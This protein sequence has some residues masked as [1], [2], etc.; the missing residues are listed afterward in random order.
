MP[1]SNALSELGEIDMVEDATTLAR[2]LEKNLRE[3][4]D[5]LAVIDSNRRLTYRELNDEVEKTA[6]TLIN[7]GVKKGDKLGIWMPNNVEWTV[8]WFS[9]TAIGGVV[10]PMD[11]WYKP[12][13][14][15][16]ILGHSDSVGVFIN[17]RSGRADYIAM[18]NEIW[19]KLPALKS[20]IVNG[21]PAEGMLSFDEIIRN[22][23]IDRKAV[24]ER[25]KENDIDDVAFILYTS[26][27]TGKPKGAMLSYHNIT[28]NAK[29]MADILFAKKEDKL[30][31]PVPF[32]HCFGNVLS[33]TMASVAGMSMYAMSAFDPEEALRVI[34][35]EKC[36]MINGVPTMFVRML[37]VLDRKH[38][39]TT[40]LRTGAMAGAPCPI[41]IM[42]G[43]IERMHCN[44]SIAYGLTEASPLITMTR[45]D[46]PIE[47]RVETV[48]R[49]IPDVEVR[50]VD[51]DRNSLPVGEMGELAC[52]GYNVMK[53]YY[54]M[55]EAT[56]ETI[57]EEG[58]LYS[59]DLA[60]R[61]DEGYISI[62]GRKKDM[63]I[64]GG[65]NVYP[66]ELEEF[67]I[68]HPKILD[69]AVV[70]V[71]D[72]DLGEIVAAAVIPAPGLEITPQEVVDY[73]Y[74]KVASAKVPRFVMI[75]DSLPISGR[76]KV[77]KFILRKQFQEKIEEGKLK[78][79]V[80]TAVR[81]KQKAKEAET[82]SDRMVS[83]GKVKTDKK[84]KLEKFIAGLDDEQE[85]ALEDIMETKRD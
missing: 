3:N 44:V 10:I 65:F 52:R 85:A 58:W 1:S 40:S 61:D 16:Y 36:T 8:A 76:G 14:S 70:G 32:S 20:V 55:P 80:P 79:M 82:L 43:T 71:P 74:G 84:E 66:R 25:R 6:T 15:E 73:S 28:K 81:Q 41:D 39:D 23:E 26:G 30:L 34:E 62:V 75:T 50:I 69:V 22:T 18:M 78:K 57:D 29:A 27:T 37:E 68:A 5:N 54:K 59:G 38:Y 63:V 9:I 2:L 49:P 67:Y 46:D 53:G 7:M 11:T 19:P 56:A 31:V 24:D 72:H 51:D 13:E 21:K 35:T 60:V 17:D 77:Q 83:S 47:K 12:A 42:K 4:P 48:G 64:V 45:F 33:I